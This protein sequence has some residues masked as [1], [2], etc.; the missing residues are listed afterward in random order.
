VREVVHK[1]EAMAMAM[2]VEEYAFTAALKDV[3]DGNMGSPMNVATGAAQPLPP[4]SSSEL[5]P[6]LGTSLNSLASSTV[7]PST[8]CAICGAQV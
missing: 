8:F 7:I 6:N 4:A 1:H 2:Q 5:T 3:A